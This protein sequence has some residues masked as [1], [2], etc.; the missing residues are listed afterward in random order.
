MIAELLFIKNSAIQVVGNDS[1]SWS[2]ELLYAESEIVDGV[3]LIHTPE[4]VGSR[5]RF[6]RGQA[7]DYFDEYPWEVCFWDPPAL[8]GVPVY[9]EPLESD[10][11]PGRD[12]RFWSGLLRSEEVHPDNAVTTYSDNYLIAADYGDFIGYLSPRIGGDSGTLAPGIMLGLEVLALKTYLTNQRVYVDIWL[13]APS[14]PAERRNFTRCRLFLF[15]AHM[16]IDFKGVV[17]LEDDVWAYVFSGR[18]A[19][20]NSPPIGTE[21]LT[22]M[23]AELAG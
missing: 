2:E 7:S 18:G 1:E 23:K 15:N 5:Y 21:V 22:K 6:E 3:T 13:A 20:V 11:A 12:W 16:A 4:A 9:G 17:N 14:N 19:D 10:D 8:G